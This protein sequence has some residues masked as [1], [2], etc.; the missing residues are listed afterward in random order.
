MLNPRRQRH[1]LSPAG[2]SGLGDELD[3]TRIDSSHP[4]R[5]RRLRGR[6]RRTSW[7]RTC[8][9]R[10]ANI[11]WASD[12]RRCPSC[13]GIS[14]SAM[15]NREL[16]RD[17]VEPLPIVNAANGEHPP[18][19]TPPNSCSAEAARSGTAGSLSLCEGRSG[20][21]DAQSLA[22]LATT[23]ARNMVKERRASSYSPLPAQ[24]W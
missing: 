20:D 14:R 9:H 3:Q 19:L 12:Q 23:L 16:V 22:A 1:E 7:H 5:A 11:P 2:A 6:G 18:K 13:K 8:H 10:G 24:T 17:V 21:M 15:S 4:C